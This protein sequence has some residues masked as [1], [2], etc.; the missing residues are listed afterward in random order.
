MRSRRCRSGRGETCNGQIDAVRRRG[1]Y[2][3]LEEGFHLRFPSS[4]TRLR[5]F[6][7]IYNHTHRRWGN[8][9][10][11]GITADRGRQW[12]RP[13]AILEFNRGSTSTGTGY[14]AQKMR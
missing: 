7:Y 5:S 2:E 9:N 3:K 4:R 10:S 11:R 13:Y 6:T 12:W 14:S 1:D 8:I